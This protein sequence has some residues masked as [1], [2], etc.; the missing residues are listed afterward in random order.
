MALAFIF[1]ISCGLRLKQKGRTLVILLALVW[2]VLPFVV[3]KRLQQISV[4]L[5]H[6]VTRVH[7]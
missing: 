3:N 7:W 2:S 1:F 5:D 4:N 6:I